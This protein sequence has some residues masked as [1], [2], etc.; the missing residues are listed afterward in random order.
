VYQPLQVM[1][2]WPRVSMGRPFLEKFADV[3]WE[4]D[5]DHLNAWKEGRTGF[6]IVDAA[7]RACNKRGERGYPSDVR[8]GDTHAAQ[9]GWRIGSGWS[10]RVSWSSL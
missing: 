9:A 4:V 7:M 1:S 10:Q 8:I 6:P 2:T 5:E 3:Q